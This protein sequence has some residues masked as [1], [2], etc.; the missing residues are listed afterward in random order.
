M[1]E[2]SPPLSVL[3][4]DDHMDAADSTAR[5]LRVA[6]GFTVAVAYD[7]DTGL[8]RAA[9][10]PPDAVVCDVSLPRVHGLE[11]GRRLSRL[12]PRPLLIA[13]TAYDGA[14]SAEL[15]YAAGFDCYLV[16]PADPFLIENLIRGCARRDAPPRDQRH[17]PP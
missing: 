13:V 7:G 5:F 14:Y 16:K 17:P 11:V 4:I 9:A 15:A 2:P 8:K 10:D 6:A 12:N 1:A 3:V